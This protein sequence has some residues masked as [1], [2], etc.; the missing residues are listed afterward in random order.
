MLVASTRSR[1]SN[2]GTIRQ[3]T[4]EKPVGLFQSVL[5]DKKM[6]YDSYQDAHEQLGFSGSYQEEIIGSDLTG[7]SSV[8]VTDH[9]DSYIQLRNGNRTIYYVGIGR[10]KSPGHPASN[11]NQRKQEPFR[12]SWAL[13]NSFPVLHKRYDGT[14]EFLGN[15]RVVDIRKRLAYEGFAYF[16]IEL[17]QVI[18]NLY[19]AYTKRPTR[20]LPALRFTH[21]ASSYN[22][23]PSPASSHSAECFASTPLF[24]DVPGRYSRSIV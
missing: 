14:V 23:P 16:E 18:E 4:A 22:H 2:L 6:A 15:Y 12:R 1:A 13:Q 19:L 17:R 11:Q 5:I 7:I 21:T 9:R 24:T 3:K 20:I 8:K 10:T